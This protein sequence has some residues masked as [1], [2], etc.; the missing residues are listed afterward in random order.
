MPAMPKSSPKTTASFLALMPQDPALTTRP[1]FGN[2]AAFIN[3]NMFAGLFGDELFV[4]L[5]E[6]ARARVKEQGGKAFEPMPGR[7]MTGYVCVATGWQAKA[8]PA[9]SSIAEA[10]A[11]TRAMPPKKPAA[12]QA[13]YKTWRRASL[14]S[15]NFLIDG[16]GRPC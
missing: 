8:A 15:Q 1:M 3:G 13:A 7:A 9:R 6:A 11:W 5:P 4:R 2:M 12:G 10:L 16:L 14:G